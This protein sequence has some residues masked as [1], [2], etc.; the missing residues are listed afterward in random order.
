MRPLTLNRYLATQCNFQ[1]FQAFKHEDLLAF[2][3]ISVLNDS[4]S[5]LDSSI[6]IHRQ[7]SQVVSGRHALLPYAIDFLAEHL[8]SSATR[9]RLEPDSHTALA[10][11]D[12]DSLQNQ[13]CQKMGRVTDKLLF[14]PRNDDRLEAIS[15]L[16][17]TSIC[18]RFLA[19]Q[20]NCKS[21]AVL[22]GEGKS[23]PNQ[24]EPSITCGQCVPG[25][26]LL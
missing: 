5:L 7:L 8:V 6:P 21:Q 17:C 24:Y 13:Y 15:N 2:S 9:N 25:N 26:G 16:P 22:T 4:L 3:C 20:Q 14:T 1:E 18:V 10:L 12:F 23:P 19:F 11:I